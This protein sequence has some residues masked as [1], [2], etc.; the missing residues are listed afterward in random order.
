MAAARV[1]T[2]AELLAKQLAQELKVKKDREQEAERKAANNPAAWV[3]AVR[4]STMDKE[5]KQEERSRGMTAVFAETERT[6][7][8]VEKLSTNRTP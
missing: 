3:T 2:A 8:A 5:A 7:A 1:L 6:R 4:N